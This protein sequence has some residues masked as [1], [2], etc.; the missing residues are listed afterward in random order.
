MGIRVKRLRLARAS[1]T[2]EP[3]EVSFQPD[4][5]AE[6]Y[7][8]LSVIAGPTQTGKTSIVDFI[9]YC[10]GGSRLPPHLE[11]HEHVRAAL[12]EV[13]LDGEPTVIERS[14]AGAPSSFATVWH[15][16]FD[17]IDAAAERRFD[18]EPTGSPD[19][20]SQFVLA[21]S[22]LDGVRLSD[23]VVKDD[24]KSAMLSIR[25]LFKVMIVANDR[26]DNKNL[27]FE[28]SNPMVAQ[29]FR[30]AIEVMFGVY[31]NEEA[32]LAERQRQ[33]T[34]A[35]NREQARLDAL[36]I[37]AERDY[38]D[39]PFVLQQNIDARG[40]DL[41]AL[42]AQLRALDAERR[43]TIAAS[44]EIRSE[45]DAARSRETKAR[46]RVRDRE[47]LLDRLDALRMQYADD[48][49]KLGFLLDA[50]ILFD[51]L[52]V[53]TCPVCFNTLEPAPFIDHGHCSLCHHPVGA[54]D[55]AEPDGRQ[56]VV[57]DELRAVTARLSS[58]SEYMTRLEAD[59]TALVRD[60]ETKTL[61]AVDAA[62][63]LDAIAD[64]PAPWLALRDRITND[65]ADVRLALQAAETG[66]KAWAWVQ[67]SETLVESLQA[68][69]DALSRQRR[70]TRPDRDQIV[71]LLSDRFAAI[72]EDVGYPKLSQA[73]VDS[74][75][76]PY[77][78]GLEYTEAS[79]GGLVV[80]A[81]AWNLALWE[82]A[83]EEEAAAPGLLI[84]DSPQKNLG[85]NASPNDDFAD[86][87]LVERFYAHAKRWLS[88]D[89]QGA[90]L[91][92][93][94]NTPPSSV[95]DDVV[96]R[97]TRQADVYPYGLIWNATS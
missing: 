53:T 73:Y 4:D 96:V 43:S 32:I 89:G 13:D 81:L 14:A 25:D 15:A 27:V 90:Q 49:R 83:F 29:K 58:L 47:S 12:L 40:V 79:S 20:L 17:N 55:E 75:F 85:H 30:Q 63:A 26:L 18:I 31:D 45:L 23:S 6:G 68:N 33:A 77:V 86:A 65:I 80:I 66:L 41:A 84:I 5:A 71:R 37:T 48:R 56:R 57:A 28:H 69:V 34:Q 38:P 24:T 21:S 10:L 1:A 92:I 94:D 78:R 7:R 82:I 87:T 35:R 76:I 52:Q 62:L 67:K 70:K 91:I 72:L 16:G 51:P 44:V 8:P 88:T 95:A 54:D 2:A 11:I 39:G 61:Q 50:D 36:R 46:L 64:S 97:F 93:I 42:N 22:D 9:A 19:G 59:R 74:N 3:Y 60:A